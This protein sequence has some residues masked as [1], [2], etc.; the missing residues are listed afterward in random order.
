MELDP[1]TMQDAPTTSEAGDRAGAA[2]EPATAPTAA[3]AATLSWRGRL[4]QRDLGSIPVLIGLVVIWALF[5]SQNDRF[6][7]AGNLTNLMLQ[8][9]ALGTVSTGIV[10]VLLL[11]E[12]DLSVGWVSGL[13]AAV[14]AVLNVKHGWPAP[15]AIGAGLG[16]GTAI[17]VV[18]GMWITRLRVPSFVV[19]LAGLLAWQGALLYVLGKTGTV[20]LNDDQ[21]T[22]LAGTFFST[23]VSW[24]IAI[25]GLVA[26]ATTTLLASRR[27]ERAGLPTPGI[28]RL[29]LR[30]A[31]VSVVA[32]A[33]VVVFTED[34]GLPLNVLIFLSLVL[35][36]SLLIERT[37]FG[38]HIYAV[39]G[40]AEAAHRAGIRVDRVR[41]AVFAICSTMAAAGGILAASRLLA[42]NQSSGGSDFLLN[43]IAAAVI[44]GTSLFGGRGAP[45]SA[46]LGALVIGSI[47]NGMDLLAFGSDVKFMI[48]GLVLV[49]AATIDA[50]GRRGRE[51][52]GR[53]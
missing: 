34:R 6:L 26:Y 15:L 9:A 21:I 23:A 3:R 4:R 50:V 5:Q 45:R 52:A 17:G 49:I 32:T 42:V 10:L 7:S 31:A 22:G 19:T 37:A 2:A 47:G 40:S 39:G 13:A 11:G 28:G 16:T 46:L 30:I 1:V 25:V 29:L 12:I 53:A 27:R 44:G 36:F 35:V 14:M 51:A 43:A 20:N 48:T 33:A 41:I 8:I 18:Q 38:R 24:T